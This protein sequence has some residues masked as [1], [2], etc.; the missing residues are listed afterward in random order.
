MY[1]LNIKGQKSTP[2]SGKLSVK[3][4]ARWAENLTAEGGYSGITISRKSDGHTLLRWSGARWT[5]R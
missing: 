1:Y 4:A 2:V 5:T 3:D